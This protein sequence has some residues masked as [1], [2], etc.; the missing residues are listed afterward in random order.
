[1]KF[2]PTETDFFLSV[3]NCVAAAVVLV[4][5]DGR[6]LGLDGVARAG[7]TGVAIRGAEIERVHLDFFVFE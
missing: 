4:A 3:D 7:Q 6:L 2:I 1:M 5:A